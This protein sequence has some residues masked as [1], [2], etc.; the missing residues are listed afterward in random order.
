[1]IVAKK[2]ILPLLFERYSVAITFSELKNQ[3]FYIKIKG[4][5]FFL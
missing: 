2:T 4:C 5:I 3:W 1:M